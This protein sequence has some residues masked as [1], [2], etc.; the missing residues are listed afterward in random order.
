M[1]NY[2]ELTFVDDFIFCKVLEDNEDLCKELLELILEKSI[3]KILFLDKQKTKD[4][5]PN[6]KSIRLDVYVKD[7][8]RS[9]Y[10]I[11]MQTTSRENLPKRTRYYQS[12]ID[13]NLMEKGTDYRELKRTYIIFICSRNPF[14]GKK[15][16]K[17][18]FENTCREDQSLLLGDEAIKVFLTPEGTEEDVS[19]KMKNFLN[20]VKGAV[21]VDD[22]TRRLSE[23]VAEKKES[24]DMKLEYMSYIANM[25]DEREAGYAE[26]HTNG[27]EEAI[28]LIGLMQ[29]HK[30]DAEQALQM[31]NV[32]EEKWDDYLIQLRKF[33]EPKI[34]V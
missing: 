9:V 4:A 23:A 7:D 32:P 6:K 34:L 20:F 28:A 27:F 29:T 10:D 22:F 5:V 3:Q 24:A 14:P 33:E 30:C 16:H 25:Q 13:I 26:G 31:A 18:S 19:P 11:E 21:P 17:Y 12:V 1:K 2:E 15:L 8:N